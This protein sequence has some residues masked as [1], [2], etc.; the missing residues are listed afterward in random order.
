MVVFVLTLSIGRLYFFIK[1]YETFS[2]VSVYD[3]ALAFLRGMR[4]DLA[5]IAIVTGPLLLAL[6]IPGIIKSRNI[7]KAVCISLLTCFIILII[8]EF[9]DIQ[10]YEYA[11]RHLTFEIENTLADTGL[12]FKIGFQKYLYESIGCLIFILGFILVFLKVTRSF[13]RH[14]LNQ[15][16]IDLFPEKWSKFYF[17]ELTSFVL[18]IPLLVI[19]VRGGFQGIPISV[20]DAFESESVELGVLSLNGVYTTLN[21]LINHRKN[22]DPYKILNSKSFSQKNID[23]KAVIKLITADENSSGYKDY[24]LMH[25]YNYLPSERRQMNV[26]IFI[27]ESWSAYYSGA[28]GGV[29]D[30]TPFFDELS[31]KGLLLTKC[32][33]NAQRSIEGLTAILG[34]LPVMNGMVLG[35]NG[36]V[37]NQTRFVTMGE[38]FKENGYQTLFVHGARHASLGFDALVR[39]I[40]IN[41]H[42]SREDFDIN[43]EIDDGLWGIF[44]EHS[45]LRADKEMRQMKEPFLTIVYSLTSHVPYLLPSK[46]FEYYNKSIYH[47]DFLNSMR[48]SD[49]ALGRFFKTAENSPYFNNTLFVIVGDHTHGSSQRGGLYDTYHIPCLFYSPG[50][51]KPGH[52]NKITSQLDLLPTIL[53]ILKFS[54]PFTS[55]GKSI[56]SPGERFAV[57]PNGDMFIFIKDPY[58]ILSD[59]ESPRALYNIENDTTFNLLSDETD[60][61]QKA[62]D[63]L[64]LQLQGYIKVSY[65]TIKENKIMPPY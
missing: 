54:T 44:D 4:F 55:W 6:F 22:G 48:Y 12:I 8:Y 10:Y 58:L 24:P 42:I 37:L 45:F 3:L 38:L 61:E 65:E 9:A 26:V 49:Y 43:S 21:S 5:T 36:G 39:R 7:V 62:A 47:G 17:P 27:M 15:D 1:Y 59:I 19:S 51:I 34:S 50:S 2:K 46:E 35:Q 53:D 40:G 30:A 64:N 32:F 56:Y 29:P 52:Y 20:H 23:S 11:Q 60:K 33:A 16:K 41:R 14:S 18:V 63:L 25:K 57:L 28:L 31:R 13:F